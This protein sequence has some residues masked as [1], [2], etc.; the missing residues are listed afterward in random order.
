[1]EVDSFLLKSYFYL[2]NKVDV[3]NSN[4]ELSELAVKGLAGVAPE[5]NIKEYT[6]YTTP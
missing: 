3:I 2:K 4:Q 6:S 5:V 1:M